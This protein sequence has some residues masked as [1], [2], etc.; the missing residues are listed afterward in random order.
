MSEDTGSFGYD[1]KSAFQAF[2]FAIF[3]YAVIE[4]VRS[5]ILGANPAVDQLKTMLPAAE[6]TKALP[7]LTWLYMA[8]FATFA[9]HLVRIYVTLELMEEEYNTFS[10]FHQEY[11][12]TGRIWDFCLR[13]A[14]V[15]ILTLEVIRVRDFDGFLQFILYFYVALVFWGILALLVGKKE[16]SGESFLRSSLAGLIA[17][18]V[19]LYG[20]DY[21]MI[22]NI[23]AAAM[24]ALLGFDLIFSRNNVFRYVWM[25][26]QKWATNW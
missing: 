12:R 17:V 8:F 11:G 9:L 19:V 6:F 1:T 20:R 26:L 13:L 4:V 16:F 23:F 18:L 25:F 24:T 22:L 15:T 7:Y 14:I 10:G 2:Y 5:L 3:G 21:W